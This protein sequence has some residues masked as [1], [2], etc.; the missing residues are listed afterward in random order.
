MYLQVG[1]MVDRTRP[2]MVSRALCMAVSRSILALRRA[3][4][5]SHRAEDTGRLSWR[6]GVGGGEGV[7]EVACGA[8]HR[9]HM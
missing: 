3:F 8:R 5:I 1:Q 2:G 9:I 7:A 4:Y 6:H